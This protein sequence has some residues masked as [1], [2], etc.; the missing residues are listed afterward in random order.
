MKIIIAPDSFKGSL[1]AREIA[2]NIE[3]GILS[4]YPQAEVI[5]LP[6]ADGGEGTVDALVY[7]T[8]GKKIYKE[9]TGPL[10]TPV[11]AYFGILGNENTAIIETA[12]AS[13][14]ALVP[15][16]KENP[17]KATT[18]GT[19]ELIKAALDEGVDKIIIGL[20]GSATVDGGIGMAQAL[21]ISFKDSKGKEVGFGG[22]ELA[23]VQSID[24]SNLDRRLKDVEFL[25]AS[26]VS[27]PLY[28]PN[29]AAYIFGP[30]KG[31]TEEMVKF[32]DDSL[33]NYARVIKNETG[34]KVG[35]L[36]GGGAAGGLGAAL[37]VFLDAYMNSGIELILDIYN[38]NT[39]LDQAALVITG[40]GRIDK[41][42]LM[43]KTPYG[44]AMRAKKYNV[45]VIAV[46]GS[47]EAEAVNE[48]NE[49]FDGIFSIMLAPVTIEKA[50]LN[51]ENWLQIIVQQ[52]MR[53]CIVHK[54]FV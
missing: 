10:G 41:Q 13:G 45:P 12:A 15:S 53:T 30:Q 4:V 23:N 34:K 5:K 40:E 43:G 47:V 46:A 38:F 1:T 17:L 26:D 50:I 52:I 32:L 28:G 19:G 36:P 2:D 6:M 25:I 37:M 48:L 8:K 39:F 35:D 18:F 11:K 3:K 31:A 51:T 16:G 33:R 21:G 42:T 22:A 7:A 9:V 27:N 44:V 24:L 54:K 49:Y 29:G 14:L 20:G